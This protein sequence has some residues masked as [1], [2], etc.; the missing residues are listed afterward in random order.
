[1]HTLMDSTSGTCRIRTLTAIYSLD[2]DAGT[3]ARV[4]VEEDATPLRRDEE[5]VTLLEL[6][7]CTLG[8]RMQLDIDLKVDGVPWTRRISTK[9]LSI[10]RMEAP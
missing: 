6:R 5:S 8:Q 2:L 4:P 9:V 10:E 3:L 1:M 7:E